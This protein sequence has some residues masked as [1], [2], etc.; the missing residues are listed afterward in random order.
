M[1]NKPPQT[2]SPTSAPLAPAR[3]SS[4]VGTVR[5]TAEK[6]KRSAPQTESLRILGSIEQ[7]VTNLR[8]ALN[9]TGGEPTRQ[10]AKAMGANR[11]GENRKPDTSSRV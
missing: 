6:A 11:P 4:P 10:D 7:S 3:T 1:T 5:E 8:V 9:G 2:N